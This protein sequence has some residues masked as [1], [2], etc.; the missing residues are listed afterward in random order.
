MRRRRT[1]RDRAIIRI[2]PHELHVIDPAFF[3]TLY[4][5]DGRWDK[6]AWTYDAFGAKVST[7]FCTGV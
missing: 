5:Q 6:P 7:V 3:E 4:R 1:K 2:S